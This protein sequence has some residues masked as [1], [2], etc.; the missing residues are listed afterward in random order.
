MQVRAIMFLG[1]L[2]ALAMQV[3]DTRGTTPLMYSALP[4]A[5]NA[6]ACCWTPAPM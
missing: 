5:S 1:V 6:C 3:C 2:G 4:A